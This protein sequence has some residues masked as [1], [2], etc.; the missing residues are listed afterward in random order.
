LD[1]ACHGNLEL[2]DGQSIWIDEWIRR[3]NGDE[4]QVIKVMTNKI[5]NLNH[6]LETNINNEEPVHQEVDPNQS[7]NLNL[8]LNLNQSE[9]QNLNQSEKIEYLLLRIRINK[10]KWCPDNIKYYIS[11]HTTLKN[12]CLEAQLQIQHVDKKNHCRKKLVN[13]EPIWIKN[14]SISI[15]CENVTDNLINCHFYKII[16]LEENKEINLSTFFKFQ[17]K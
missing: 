15:E 16:K 12:A 14:N 7:E 10:K 9:N 6:N 8:N 5:Y 11:F 1:E 4:Y 3:G 2:S 17:Q 13:L